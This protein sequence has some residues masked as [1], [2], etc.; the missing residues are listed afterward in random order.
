MDF[1]EYFVSVPSA[2]GWKIIFLLANVYKI[3]KSPCERGIRG[4]K[5]PWRFN[6]ER[7]KNQP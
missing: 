5:S 1:Y 6:M 4:V 7:A 3:K 2:G